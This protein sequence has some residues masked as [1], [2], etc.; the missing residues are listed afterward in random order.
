MALNKVTYV[1]GETVITAEN[2]NDIQDAIIELEE[3]GGGDSDV[4]W[5]VYGT[6]TGS[7]VASAISSEKFVALSYNN[8]IMPLA[9][10]TSSGG[11]TVYQFFNCRGASYASI[12]LNGDTWS[13][14][15]TGTLAPK[16]SPALT[17]TPTAP[18][19]AAGT[20]TTQ[21]ATTAFVQQEINSRLS[22]VYKA[23]GSVV[24]ISALPAPSANYLGYV[25]D[26]ESAFTTTADF[27]EG[28]GVDYPAGT[29]VA[30]I[31][32][33]SGGT[34]SY[35]YDAL[36][37]FVDL[38]RYIEKPANASENQVMLFDGTN[39]VA[40]TQFPEVTVSTAGAVTQALDAG[41]LYHFTGALTAL[42]I[43]LNA[44][45]SGQLAQYHFDFNCG[46]TAPTVTIPSTV[47]MPDAN[48]FEASKHYE[49]DILN[50]YGAV[51]SWAN[52]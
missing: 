6:T 47:H 37:G 11:V 18:T 27:V 10:I 41:K 42:T 24:S 50:N 43:T 26:V 38:S 29:D 44:A 8:Y 16:T 23:A 7:E 22:T 36:S 49:V 46:S 21:I 3:S 51:I 25:Y 12:S 28:A 31:A 15:S 32:V 34:T 9:F 30:I 20:D 19:A 52:S 5:A 39:W 45:P 33:Q 2:L 14:L 48:S 13:G 40:A 35:K 4:F 17:G 1:D